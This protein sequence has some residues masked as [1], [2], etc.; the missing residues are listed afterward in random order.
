M[1]KVKSIHDKSIEEF[2]SYHLMLMSQDSIIDVQK[3][4]VA[5]DGSNLP[6]I[7]SYQGQRF[8]FKSVNMK[9]K[10]VVLTDENDWE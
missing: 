3:V 1:K 2:T 7:V 8:W 4:D 9:F 5:A 10:M 6:R